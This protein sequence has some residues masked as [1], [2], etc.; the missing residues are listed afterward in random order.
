MRT[1]WRPE[2]LDRLRSSPLRRALFR[3]PMKPFMPGCVMK[4]LSPQEDRTDMKNR[5]SSLSI[6]CSGDTC[7][8]TVLFR[9]RMLEVWE[10]GKV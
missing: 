10:E 8:T 3:V 1:V 2:L 5:L 7:L 9:D 4:T 6:K